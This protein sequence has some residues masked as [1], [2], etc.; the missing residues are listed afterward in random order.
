MLVIP[1][2]FGKDTCDGYSR[3]ELLRVGGSAFFGLSLANLLQLQK[4]TAKEGRY[5]G[6]GF[7]KAKHVI[8]LYLQGGP[9]HLDLWDP[10][11]N[12]PDNVKSVFNTIDTKVPGVHLGGF[13]S[14]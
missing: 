9:S 3:R 14:M 2:S 8:L 10:K 13:L 5:G 4:A 6:P 7:D 12:V 11:T 1:G